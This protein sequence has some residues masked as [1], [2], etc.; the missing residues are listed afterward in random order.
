MANDIYVQG[1]IVLLLGC[2]SATGIGNLR[3]IQQIMAEHSVL[4]N[5]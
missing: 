2:I 3:L 5:S 1:R 4:A